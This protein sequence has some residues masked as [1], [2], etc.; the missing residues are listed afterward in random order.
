LARARDAA[1][2]QATATP[3]SV[4]VANIIDTQPPTVSITS[5]IDGATVSSTITVSA[6]ASDNV[7]VSGVQFLLDN[8][9]LGAEVTSSPYSVLWNTL[10]ANNGLHSLTARARDAAGNQ[11]TSGAVSV[12]VKNS[13]STPAGLV[14][15]YNFNE[16]SGATTTDRSGNG[17]TGTLSG[18]SWTASGKYGKALAFNGVNNWLT[19][20]DSNLLDLT[21]AMTLEA[22]VYPTVAP[23]NWRT[24][25]IKEGVS[26]KSA[27]YL[28]A[29]SDPS[30]QPASGLTI[31]STEYTLKGG[32][33]PAAN[34]WTHLATTY[35][36]AMLRL[37]VNGTQVAS[38]ARTGLITTTANP[39]RIGGNSL[40]GEYFTGRIDEVRIYNRALT[41]PEIQ[42][43]LNT[44]IP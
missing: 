38:Q 28:Y 1:G 13:T 12:T 3:V 23:S 16:G 7:G 25:L 17:Q 15:A 42:T 14:A 34:T 33:R 37:Y 24:I 30:N 6:N 22:W 11:A 8:V 36:G 29:S 20:N 35:D 31:G 32:T 43:D 5:P 21:T 41:Q 40:F 9:N 4:T 44:P 27:Y 39:L 19:V 18:A 26:P 2:N 10:P